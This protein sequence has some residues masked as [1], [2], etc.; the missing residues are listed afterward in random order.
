MVAS[1]PIS[2]L[3]GSVLASI[4]SP[5][6]EAK[7]VV[8]DAQKELNTRTFVERE[9]RRNESSVIG[10]KGAVYRF[11]LLKGEQFLVYTCNILR[12]VRLCGLIAG[13]G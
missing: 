7:P 8:D 13:E 10:L 12:R 6:G 3:F 1:V 9:R 4:F 5:C 11:Q 2:K